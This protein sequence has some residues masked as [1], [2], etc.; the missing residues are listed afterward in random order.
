MKTTG[1]KQC[2][3]AKNKKGNLSALPL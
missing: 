1:E 2:Q 3:Y